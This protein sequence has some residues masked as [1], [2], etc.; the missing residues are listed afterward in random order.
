[1]NQRCQRT[2]YLN[3]QVAASDVADAAEGLRRLL[4]RV[5]ELGLSPSCQGLLLALD[6]AITIATRR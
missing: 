6:K 1:M 4:G 2:V 5:H 3:L